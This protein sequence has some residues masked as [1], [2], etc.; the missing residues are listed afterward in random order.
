MRDGCWAPCVGFLVVLS[1]VA[2]SAASGS[3][4]LTWLTANTASG[5]GG[6]V[7]G[8]GGAVGAGGSSPG[9]GG[10]LA[11]TGVPEP[12][13]SGMSSGLGGSNPATG[14]STGTGGIAPAAG[15]IAPA[16]GGIA[17]AAGGLAPA[18][19]GDTAAGGSLATGGSI[20]TGGVSTA[21]G[22]SSSSS[23][24][25]VFSFFVTSLEAMRRLSGSQNGFGGDLRYGQA[26]GLTG[27]DKICTEIAEYS[28]PGAA[29]K[30]WRAFLSSTTGGPDGGPVHAI[31]RIGEGPWYD[32][33][34][35]VVAMTKDALLNQRPQGADPAIIDDLPNE[36][37]IPNHAPDGQI[38]DNHD[39]L[40]GT[41]TDGRLYGDAG[42]TC[43]DWTSSVASSGKPRC[44][45]TWPTSMGGGGT[46]G[47]G[48]F[49]AGGTVGGGF[50]SGMGDLAHWISALDEA[51][52]AAGVN[53][54]E[55]GGPGTDGTQTVGSGGGYGAI[56]CFALTP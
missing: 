18:A 33:V 28:M 4:D 16:A 39:T 50:D 44:G 46:F 47:G 36:Y 54:A 56:Y 30:V 6:L 29:Q 53:L 35:R 37:G 14:G 49:G 42:S 45:H 20:G 41:G 43:Q 11:P 52:C 7:P 17:P 13:A 8:T 2:C 3:E 25:P 10:S 22:G 24:L 26:D 12:A 9:L 23:D 38:V 40:T 19:G 34:G 21:T 1:S 32:R 31:D 5:A 55:T 48:T 15:G 27:A 51:G